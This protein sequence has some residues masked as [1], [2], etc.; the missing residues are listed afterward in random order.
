MCATS[1]IT[2]VQ[3]SSASPISTTRGH[4]ARAIFLLL[5]LCQVAPRAYAQSAS[6]APPASQG[7]QAYS[8]NSTTVLRDLDSSIDE[9]AVRVVPAVVQVLV[10]GLGSSRRLGEGVIEHQRGIGS[11][12]IVDP[13]GFVMTNAHVVSGARRIRVQLT[14][15]GSELVPGKTSLLRRQRIYEAKLLGIHRLTDLALL[16]IDASDLPYIPLKETF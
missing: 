14:P 10:S 12:V 16:K 5:A 3:H 2:I 15:V 6:I 7:G 1:L 4:A 8:G 11:G 13:N 9:M